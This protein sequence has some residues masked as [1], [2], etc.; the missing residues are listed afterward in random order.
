[1]VWLYKR[2]WKETLANIKM[3]PYMAHWEIANGNCLQQSQLK[4]F[5]KTQVVS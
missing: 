4:S 1:M 5:Q 2:K 3:Y